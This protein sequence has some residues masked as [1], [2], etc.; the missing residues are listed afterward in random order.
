MINNIESLTHLQIVELLEATVK[1]DDVIAIQSDV[2]QLKVAYLYSSIGKCNDEMIDK[3]YKAAFEIYKQNKFKYNKSNI[4]GDVKEEEI[5]V[6]YISKKYYDNDDEQGNS[7]YNDNL[8]MD[9][10]SQDFWDSL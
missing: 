1:N 5:V 3:R 9:Q 4:K 6:N 2:V 10:Q 8:D 7:Y